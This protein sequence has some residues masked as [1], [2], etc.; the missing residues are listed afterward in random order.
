M[1]ESTDPDLLLIV[2]LETLAN[3]RRVL[4]YLT[5]TREPGPLYLESFESQPFRNHPEEHFADL[6][7]DI[8]WTRPTQIREWLVGRGAQLCEELLP[9]ELRLRLWDQRDAVRTLQIHSDELWIPWE[10]LRFQD[11]ADPAAGLFLVE[12]FGVTRW[13]FG[14]PQVLDLPL[15]RIALVVP[16]D[17]CLPSVTAERESV[18]GLG[19]QV[20]EVVEIPARFEAV[21]G[22]LASGLY[23]GFHFAGH[24]LDW[25]G[26]RRRWSILLEDSEQLDPEHLYGPARQLGRGRPLVFLNA[27]H[28]GR[29]AT[30]LTGMGG[31]ASA[32]LKAGAAAFIGSHWELTDSQ[33]THFAK[34][35]YRHV[36]AGEEIGEAVRGARLELRDRFPES[37]GWLAYAVFAHPLARCT[38]PLQ[39]VAEPV[40][41]APPVAANSP[42]P[43]ENPSPGDE[44]INEKDG[45][46]LVW[47]PGGE[48]TPPFWVGKF[49]VTNEQYA[50]YLEESRE[51]PEPAF[52]SDPRFNHPRHPVVGVSWDEARAYC[53]W[54][55]LALPTEEQWEAAARGGGRH[56]HPWGRG[57]PTPLH[58]NFGGM[59]AGTT[60]VDAYAAG[61]GPYGTFDQAG[62]VWEWCA[63]AEPSDGDEAF[64][65]LR[66]GSWTSPAEDLHVS[67]RTREPARRRLNSVGFRCVW[68]LVL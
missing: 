19:G 53:E 5:K 23:E 68:G 47:I 50:R 9:K 29:G 56:S 52:W 25:G 39:P 57:L 54:A 48:A 6:F 66:G 28:S 20:R 59:K 17:S 46:I 24:G 11:H 42:H 65:P 15:R 27:C 43:P 40:P 64:R 26:G 35:F 10:L 21:Q 41:E 67:S 3:G 51:A 58:A 13:P 8:T 14:L 32:F 37:P 61:R 18:Q 44:W 45:T 22:A 36:L 34:A 12:A 55:G 1:A 60:P 33:A 2:T 30:S 49:L 4:R 16:R 31:L 62:N 63:A 7:R 38:T